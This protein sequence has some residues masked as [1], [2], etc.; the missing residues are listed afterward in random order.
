[1]PARD[2]KIDPLLHHPERHGIYTVKIKI[3]LRLYLTSPFHDDYELQLQNFCR[4]VDIL[5]YRNFRKVEFRVRN[6]NFRV[7]FFWTQ[8]FRPEVRSSIFWSLRRIGIFGNLRW[9][10]SK[11]QVIIYRMK[12]AVLFDQL[13]FSRNRFH[14]IRIFRKLTYRVIIFGSSMRKN[15]ASVC[16]VC[17]LNWIGK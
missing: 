14:E 4:F 2:L 10:N 7:R 1:M 3:S 6:R 16:K 17:K 13:M 15:T 8:D 5:E 11:T 12:N 9:N